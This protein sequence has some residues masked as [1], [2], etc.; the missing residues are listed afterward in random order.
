M[1]TLNE[2]ETAPIPFE[3]EEQNHTRRLMVGL[4]C[5]LILTG[6][7]FGGYLYLRKRHDSEVARVA[8]A[9][10]KPKIA[11]PK[12]EVFVD[13]AMMKDTQTVL[14]GTLHNISN[15]S[16]REVSVELLLRRRAGSGVEA[17]VV[18]ANPA[19][20]APDG[21]SRYSLII[22]SKDY[23]TV[24]LGRILAGDNRAEVPFKS[25]PGAQRPPVAPPASKTIIIKRPAPRGVQIL[26]SPDKPERVP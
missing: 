10:E 22:N 1:Q 23:I 17:K 2:L 14:G 21:T 26:N 8:A 11:P 13:D 5:A 9:N 12:L 3:E 6:I 19:D 24:V 16:L 4:L 18:Q 7:L 20:L 25:L 15:A